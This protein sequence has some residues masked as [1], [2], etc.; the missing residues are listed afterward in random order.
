MRVRMKQLKVDQRVGANEL[1]CSTRFTAFK[2]FALEPGFPSSVESTA[3]EM[4]VSA[5]YWFRK[6]GYLCGRKLPPN[7][8]YRSDCV[9]SRASDSRAAPRP[10]RREDR[11]PGSS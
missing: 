6:E 10:T 3:V 8:V 1:G 5:R 4:S 9:R 2:I 7:S 11:L